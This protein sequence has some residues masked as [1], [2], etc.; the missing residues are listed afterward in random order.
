MAF[1]LVAGNLESDLRIVLD[2][3]GTPEDISDATAITMRWLKPDGSIV[4][5]R[6]LVADDA[7]GGLAAGAVKCV[8][9]AGETDVEGVHQAQVNVVRG[10]GETQTFPSNGTAITWRVHPLLGS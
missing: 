4:A 2:I 10:N 8:W 9:T 6:T 3:N 1:H 5:A 7:G